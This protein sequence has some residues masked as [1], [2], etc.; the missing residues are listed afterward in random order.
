MTSLLCLA[1][2]IFFEAGVE[3]Y[4]GKLAV[5]DV[6]H[7]R[8]QDERYPNDIC[9]VVYEPNQFSFTHDGKSDVLPNGILAERSVIAAIASLTG[10]TL[11]LTSTHYLANYAS[12]SWQEAFDFDGRIGVHMFY[13]NNTPFR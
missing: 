2:A 7:N 9:S 13:T 6:I 5:A 1:T 3:P 11:G 4:D 8:V 12:A 10:D